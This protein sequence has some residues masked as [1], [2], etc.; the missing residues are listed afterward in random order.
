MQSIV[1][2]NADETVT[3]LKLKNRKALYWLNYKQQGPAPRKFGREVR[4][5]ESEVLAF[6]QNLAAPAR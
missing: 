6:I 4:Y 5:V 3:L 2:L 1:L